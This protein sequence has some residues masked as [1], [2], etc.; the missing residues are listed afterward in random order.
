MF[1]KQYILNIWDYK[2]S[3][4][5]LVGK[6]FHSF[7]EY[8]HSGLD[9]HSATKKAYEIVD[10]VADKDIE[11]G[12]TGSREKI[13]KELSQVIDIYLSSTP[14]FGETVATEYKKT[15]LPTI[16]GQAWPLPIKAVT[17]RITR[18][19]D[20]LHLIDYKVTAALSDPA[21]EKPD[22]IMQA[23]FNYFTVSESMQEP[24][25]D[26]TF[27]EIKKSISK[28][29]EPQ[30]QSYVIDFQK[31]AEYFKYFGKMY[32]GILQQLSNEEY[33]FLPN[34]SDFLSAKEAW[35]D[36]TAEIMDFK[37]P[38]QV[39]HRSA[40]TTSVD[41]SFVESKID[42]QELVPTTPQ[43]KIM[44][45]MMEF[46]V[47]LEFSE[48][49]LGP[50]VSMYAFK[51]SRGVRMSQVEK[52]DKDLQLALETRSVRIL[53]PIPGKKLVGVEIPSENQVIVPLSAAPAPKTPLE[54]PIGVDIYGHAHTLDLTKAPHLLV[55]GSTGSGKSV[56][57]ATF[58]QSLTRHNTTVDLQLLLIDPKRSEFTDFDECAHL[59]NPIVSEVELAA[60]ALTSLV[61][62]ME[63]RYK[64]LQG[65]R[66][67][68][69][70]SYRAQN[71]DMPYLV[72]VIDELADLL[73]S[74]NVKDG[75]EKNIIRLAQKAR[76]VGIHLI[77]ATQRP[78][79]DVVTGILKAN[80]PTRLAFTTATQ[81]DSKVILDQ[82]GAEKL[83]GS[84]D[85]L[86]M[87]PRHE[88]TRLQGYF[89]E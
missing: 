50:T 72:V 21:E 70:A 4:S 10:S 29:G 22:Y 59:I 9:H 51:P 40:V 41:R 67:K 54:I 69:I 42:E 38:A 52:F 45:K 11:F 57:L 47:P 27:F 86:L 78:S 2:Q 48:Q 56:A 14:Q 8:Y 34:F 32:A 28:N 84:G 39:V 81:M 85:C 68:N 26:M 73:L 12:K 55:A 61:E 49:Y 58:I 53:A 18:R 83:I 74:A 89:V 36:F 15:V 75:I 76:A 13:L 20:G 37:M 82:G 5:M 30:T 77:L 3:P 63:D 35:A 64:I 17:D 7:A 80:F 1:K 43:E 24:V 23:M 33:Q 71:G 87:Q 88:L 66:V 60:D 16:D 62:E 31:H 46:G 79:V 6:A 65:A 25:V 19:S 44:T